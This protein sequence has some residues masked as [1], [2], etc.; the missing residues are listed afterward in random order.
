MVGGGRSRPRSAACSRTSCMSSAAT[1]YAF[2][3]RHATFG[4][5]PPQSVLS[6]IATRAPCS[7]NAFEAPSRAADPAPSTMRSYVSVAIG[8]AYDVGPGGRDEARPRP[9]RLRL[10]TGL[11]D[12]V[13]ECLITRVSD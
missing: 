2:V 11:P 4:H 6:T 3:G 7:R 1:R 12:P 10:R 8:R 9:I 5:E 13:L